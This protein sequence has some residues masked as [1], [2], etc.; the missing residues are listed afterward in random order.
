MSNKYRTKR[1]KPNAKGRNEY[2][3]FIQI[4]AHVFKCAS[5]IS[6]SGNAAKLLF[7][8][9]L[10]FNGTNNGEIYLSVRKAGE[11]CGI[12]KGT[13]QRCINELIEKGFIKVNTKGSFDRKVKHATTYWLTMK[14][15][16]GEQPTKEY[17]SWKPEKQKSVPKINLNSIKNYDRV[18]K[19]IP[20]YAVY[21]TNNWYRDWN[22]FIIIGTKN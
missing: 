4:D 7:Q 8:F 1:K 15:N 16:P 3:R 20:Y 19:L 22:K 9:T 21:D 2:K 17:M 6:L 10:L 5:Y 12:S 13:A 14:A 11:F 18:Q